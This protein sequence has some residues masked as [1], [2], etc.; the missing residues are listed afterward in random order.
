MRTADLELQRDWTLGRFLGGQL[1][2]S[3]LLNH[4]GISIITILLTYQC[5]AACSHCV[6]ESS[7]QNKTAL[8]MEVAYKLVQAASRQK[9]PPVLGFSGG[10]PFLRVREMRALIE[11][12]AGLGMPSEVVSSS[13][14]AKSEAY[15][16]TVLDDLRQVGLQSYCTSVDQFHTPFV[17]PEKMRWSLEAAKR[18]GLRTIINFQAAADHPPERAG[19]LR[20]ISEIL[21]IPPE[22]VDK[23]HIN[24]LITTPVGRARSEVQDFL[25]DPDKNMEEGCPMATE[26]VTLSPYG[27]LYPCCGMVVGEKPEAAELFIQ[28]SLRDKSVDEIA[29]ILADLQSD[30]FFR[31]LQVKGP[32]WILKQLQR[33]DPSLAINDKYVGACDVCLEFTQN[34]KIAAATRELV[35]EFGEILHGGRPVQAQPLMA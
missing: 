33:R 24:P 16:E 21:Q 19:M 12:A 18:V 29:A 27:L 3:E 10:E 2:S 30:L 22:E 6:F 26:V 25:Y 32:Y 23:H 34:P 28:D 5:P 8:D 35:K 17:S 9:P 15:A 31:L 20:M 11:Y 1:P 7:P 14:W 13:A 4:S